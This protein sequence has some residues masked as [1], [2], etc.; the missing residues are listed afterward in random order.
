MATFHDL[1]ERLQA[2][3]AA[4]GTDPWD[5]AAFEE[6]ALL[7]FA[8]QYES[9]TPYRALCDARG[10]TPHTV[11]RWEDTPLVPATGFK[12]FDFLGDES[13]RPEATFQTSGTTRGLGARGR[14]HVPSLSLY[15]AALLPPLEAA[16]LP[17]PGE[18]RMVSLIPSPEEA[19]DSSLSVMVGFAAEA[20]ASRIDWL[21]DTSGRWAP[22]S[23]SVLSEV[24]S[25]DEPILLLGTALA[26]VG[27][28]R[29]VG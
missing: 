28:R 18:M 26:F 5:A 20:R 16:L 25:A 11:A 15:R 27:C 17:E 21:V 19:P 3:F 4:T 24:A 29:G 14:H 23:A 7:V 10:V 13:G 22:E 6:W 8:H 1:A 12:H 2:R 9:C